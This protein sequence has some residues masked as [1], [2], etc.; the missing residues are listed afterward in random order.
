MEAVGFVGFEW[1]S[2]WFGFIR[3]SLY[4]FV[5][6]LYFASFF[7]FSICCVNFSGRACCVSR[8]RCGRRCANLKPGLDTNTREIHEYNT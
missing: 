3:T 8:R 4:F 5:A 6:S 7:V 2:V 1:D